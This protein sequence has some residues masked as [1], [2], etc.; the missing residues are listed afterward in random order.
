MDEDLLDYYNKELTFLKRSAAQFAQENPQAASQL[1][2]SA[3]AIEDPHV[4]HLIQSVAFLNGRIRKKLEDEFPELNDTLLDVLYPHYLQPIPSM[5]VVRFAPQKGLSE[6]YVIP[7]DT[8]LETHPVEGEPVTFRTAY[9][10]TLWPFKVTNAELIEGAYRAPPIP[11]Y[12]DSSAVIKIQL[13]CDEED[14]TFGA[15]KPDKIRF[16][17]R[18]DSGIAN[19]LYTL[20]FNHVVGVSVADNSFDTSPIY[21]SKEN[22]A[23]VGF[24]DSDNLLEYSK[25][26]FAGYRLLTEFFSFSKKFMFFDVTGLGKKLKGRG[27]KI[28]LFFYLNKSLPGVSEFVDKTTFEL[29]CT[30]IVNLF[31]QRAEPIMADGKREEYHI[32]PDSRQKHSKEIYQVKSV[33]VTQKDGDELNIPPYYSLSHQEE[34]AS[35]H[36]IFWHQQRRNAEHKDKK[37]LDYGTEVYLSLVN[38]NYLSLAADKWIINVETVCMNR[39]MPKR[40]PFGGGQPALFLREGGL[41]DEV[42]CL[43]P[44]T[45]TTRPS[46]QHGTRWRLIS[47]LSLNHLP[48]YDNE[49]LLIALKE[50]L[51]LYNFDDSLNTQ[52]M[53]NG[54]ESV[55][56]RQIASRVRSHGNAAICRGVEI[57]LTLDE[58]RYKDQ[59]MLLFAS[60]MER[61]FALYAP[62]NSFTRLVLKTRQ[63]PEAVKKWTPRSSHHQIA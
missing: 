63:K 31:S 6:D 8:L 46:R 41:I 44:P 35:S 52:A 43:V 5:S 54:I 62:I 47:H 15:L 57:T 30:P 33:S 11:A 21:L 42:E 16:Y 23:A 1:R 32:I 49:Q 26:S 22:I 27:Q 24:D 4:E 20:L 45:Q 61:F 39:D 36:G 3:D 58:S 10:T 38:D 48:L 40:L 34:G 53:I 2:I 29:G 50:L 17:L 14:I 25:R 7:K 55:T 28:E 13:T 18:A 60:V 12:L 56:S 37:H 19:K 51:T 9:P 59:N